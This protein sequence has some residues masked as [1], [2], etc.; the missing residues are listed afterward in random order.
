MLAYFK[1]TAKCTTV[2]TL[3]EDLT[4]K[5][6]CAFPKWNPLTGDWDF[7]RDA[8]LAS[9]VRP[10]RN[11]ALI[12]CDWTQLPDAPLTDE[13][14]QAWMAYRQALRDLPNNDALTPEN[15]TWPEVP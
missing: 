3:T 13:R 12:D 8:W 10:L 4:Q 11:K 1:T 6:P 2:D 9:A 15:L 7:D 5:V 14:K